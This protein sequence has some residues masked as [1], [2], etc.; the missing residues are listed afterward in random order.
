MSQPGPNHVPNP[1][2]NQRLWQ[3]W[4]HK[5]REPDK[6]AAKNRLKVLQGN[7]IL[8]LNATQ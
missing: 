5:N 3:A 2:I 7:G 1:E 4:I 8:S 6:A